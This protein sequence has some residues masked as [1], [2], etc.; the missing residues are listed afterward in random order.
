MQQN[1]FIV[2][3]SSVNLNLTAE[4]NINVERNFIVNHMRFWAD[5]F[6][7]KEKEIYIPD[8]CEKLGFVEGKYKIGEMIRFLADML[9]E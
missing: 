8:E 7:I 2:D 5:N 1:I 3:E 9:E 4:E 6:Q